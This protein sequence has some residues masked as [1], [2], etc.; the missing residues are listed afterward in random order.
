M[1][2]IHIDQLVVAISVAGLIASCAT[3]PPPLPANNP[4]DPQV[5]GSSRMPRDLLAPD[6]TTL[7]IQRQLAATQAYAETAEEMK[8]DMTNTH[9]M[10][11]GGMKM[12]GHEGMEHGKTAPEEKKALQNE[13]KKTSDEMKATSDTM[14]KKSDETKSESAPIYTCPMHPQVQSDKAGNCPICGMKLK[15]AGTREEH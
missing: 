10:Q 2:K 5:R 6:E 14:K 15:K 1:T 12:E 13:M 11:H 3:N 4:A 7:A 8:H 9:G